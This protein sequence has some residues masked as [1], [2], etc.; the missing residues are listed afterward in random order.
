[1]SMN[2]RKKIFTGVNKRILARMYNTILLK[3]I[4]EKEQEAKQY[5]YEFNVKRV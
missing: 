2:R 5:G 3:A 1:M 4:A